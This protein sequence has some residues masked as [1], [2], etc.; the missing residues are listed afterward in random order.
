M[1]LLLRRGQSSAVFTPV[2]LR[3]GR[4]IMFT[5]WAKAEL[6]KEEQALVRRYQLDEA[7]LILDDFF[8]NLR[9]SIRV[10]LIN[11][12][13][14]GVVLSQFI[15]LYHTTLLTII[16]TLCTI[17]VYYNEIRENIYVRDLL[18]G[19]KFRCFSVVDLV[20]KEAYLELISNYLRQVLETAKHWDDQ[21]VVEIKPL[22][23]AE[24][25]ALVLRGT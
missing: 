5:L 7:P 14:I 18:H 1:N 13:V 11:G 17:F 23:R 19:R 2:P 16:A 22:P 10:G 3:I 6:D 25:K 9:K 21:E 8:E 12:A 15:G 4:G 20:K 24:A